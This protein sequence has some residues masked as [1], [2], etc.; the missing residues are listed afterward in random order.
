MSG[1]D[2]AAPGVV[3]MTRTTTTL[4]NGTDGAAFDPCSASFNRAFTYDDLNRLRT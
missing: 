2:P 4:Y 3:Q 1:Y